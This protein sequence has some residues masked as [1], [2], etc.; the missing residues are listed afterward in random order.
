MEARN[1][2]KAFRAVEEYLKDD[3][4]HTPFFVA[5]DDGAD[6]ERFCREIASRHSME[7]AR[8][9]DFCKEEDSFPDIDVLNKQLLEQSQNDVV[10]IGVGD[11]VRLYAP[12]MIARLRDRVFPVKVLIP[13]RGARNVLLSICAKDTKFKERQVAFSS[14]G[15]HVPVCTFPTDFEVDAV[16]GVKN[17]LK[18]LENAGSGNE[19]IRVLTKHSLNGV[20]S[21][22]SAYEA[23]KTKHPTVDVKEST[24]SSE[25]W[26]LLLREDCNGEYPVDDWRT[27]LKYKIVPPQS[28]TY[29][30]IAL[31]R[32]SNSDEWRGAVI[33]SI[34][35]VKASER[36]FERYYNER[37]SLIKNLS[38]GG[39]TEAA[40]AEY[41]ANARR[42]PLCDMYMYLSD[43]TEEECKAIVESVSSRDDIPRDIDARYPRFADYLRTFYFAFVDGDFWT[44]Y[45]SCY[46]KCKVL[47]KIDP[48]F[49]SVVEAE[50]LDRTHFFSL[51]TRGMVL[52]GVRSEM[53]GLYWLD[54]L[55][56]EYLGYIQ[57]RAREFSLSMKVTLARANLPT[58]TCYNKDFYS[59]W[60]N[61]PKQQS[62]ALDEI[63]HEGD[64]SLF[65]YSQDKKPIHIPAQLKAIDKAMNWIAVKLNEQNIRKIVLT[66]DHGA[67]RLA[68]INEHEATWEMGTRGEHS[69]RC[70]PKDEIGGIPECAIE[71]TV[72]DDGKTFWV[73][74]NYDRFKGGRKASV[75]VHGGASLEEA[76][77]PVIEFTRAAKV[78]VDILTNSIRLGSEEPRITLFSPARLSDVSVVVCGTRYLAQPQRSDKQ[79]EVVLRGFRITGSHIA[80]VFE[81]DSEIASVRFNVEGRAARIRDDNFF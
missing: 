22:S 41:I 62:K 66:S 23:W 15:S 47:N 13:C 77:V 68:V 70:C 19:E 4:R 42:I 76:V 56:C 73:L 7:F 50:A 52:D 9:H 16:H 69:G 34:L 53:P 48:D 40:A 5:L 54:A 59:S 21:I 51:R 3:E 81:G 57:A 29:L 31:D 27:F 63:A 1:Y 18:A 10:L 32:A 36:H 2:E 75:E 49:L 37:K 58:L 45:F 67:S 11:A 33:N 55:G 30:S 25:Q 64:E 38:N 24:L 79:I 14:N 61:L 43:L 39:W 8:L 78:T 80:T 60:S 72:S 35:T 71:E 17:L 6:Y 44:D 26:K 28:G 12:D 65:D 74:A 46:K 20:T